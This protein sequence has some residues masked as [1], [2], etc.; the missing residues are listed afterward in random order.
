MFRKLCRL[1]QGAEF[2]ILNRFQEPHPLLKQ[3]L[4]QAQYLFLVPL[5]GQLPPLL[6]LL[7]LLH[8]SQ[9]LLLL[10]MSGT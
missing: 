9:T 5:L 1:P 6:L 4:Q 7:L 2:H 3:L 10:R 8:L